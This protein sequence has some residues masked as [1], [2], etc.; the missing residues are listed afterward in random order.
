[1]EKFKMTFSPS[2]DF[3]V[4]IER[5][6]YHK[7]VNEYGDKK[8]LPLSNS[9]FFAVSNMM[10]EN[11]YTFPKLY[12]SLTYLTG[13]N[14]DSYDDYKGSFCFSFLLNVNKNNKQSEY[15][16]RLIHYRSYIDF[17]VYLFVPKKDSRDE[18][19]MQKPDD[20]L[21]S[22]KEIT[23]FSRF[24]CQ[25]MIEC[26]DASKHKPQPFINFA[27]SN[28]ILFGYHNDEYFYEQF[29]DN[30]AYHAEKKK[31][32]A[33]LENRNQQQNKPDSH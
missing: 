10:S 27:D 29:S 22:D 16:Y 31:L 14:D 2:A 20:E 33:S 1:M 9:A 21:F 12:A 23:S 15:Y 4:T 32:I 25:Y 30:G 11:P 19:V 24:F 3:F 18:E 7:I 13:P 6:D 26:L 5:I 17:S 8:L 28:L